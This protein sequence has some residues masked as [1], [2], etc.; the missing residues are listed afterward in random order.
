MLRAPQFDPNAPRPREKL[1][2][3]R[4]YGNSEF[5]AAQIAPEMGPRA[6]AELMARLRL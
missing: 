6:V 1:Y 3:S 4:V 2:R 5:A